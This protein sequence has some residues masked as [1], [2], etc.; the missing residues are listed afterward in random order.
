MT[1][2][3]ADLFVTV[4]GHARGKNAPA[5]Y[6]GA[7]HSDTTTKPTRNEKGTTP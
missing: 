3:T 1:T 5:N 6:G 4:D 2:L 7:A